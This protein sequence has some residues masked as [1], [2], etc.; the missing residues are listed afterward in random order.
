MKL[1]VMLFMLA[2]TLADACVMCDINR[3]YIRSGSGF[4]SCLVEPEGGSSC[5][6]SCYGE[7]FCNRL[8][9]PEC[10][11]GGGFFGEAASFKA[12]F[13]SNTSSVDNNQFRI[14]RASAVADVK[15][16]FKASSSDNG[17]TKEVSVLTRIALLK[18]QKTY[19]TKIPSVGQFSFG[20]PKHKADLDDMNKG[21]LLRVAPENKGHVGLAM[22]KVISQTSSETVVELM[23]YLIDREMRVVLDSEKS[24]VTYTNTE[25]GYLLHEVALQGAAPQ[26]NTKELL[27]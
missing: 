8:V 6:G 1:V 4:D 2:P 5:A 23:V 9:T 22:Y 16:L 18:I 14:V 26:L 27:D 10:P 12:K 17:V 13:A 3:C 24:L 7:P 20:T 15:K 21:Q 11:G 19:S 25:K